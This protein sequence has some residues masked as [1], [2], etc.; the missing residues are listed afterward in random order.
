MA[1][2]PIGCGLVGG[3]LNMPYLQFSVHVSDKNGQFYW[4]CQQT[5]NW[6]I[7]AQ[8]ET[9]HNRADCESAINLLIAHAGTAS[10]I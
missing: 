9:Y 4:R 6:E 7:V 3:L 2:P 1:N 8:S 10:K 5:G